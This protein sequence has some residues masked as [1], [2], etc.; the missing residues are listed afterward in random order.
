MQSPVK[1]D[2]RPPLPL[3]PLTVL[4]PLVVTVGIS[5][6]VLPTPDLRASRPIYLL[7]PV[8][9]SPELPLYPLF[10][11]F[12]LL[13]YP[14]GHLPSSLALLFFSLLLSLPLPDM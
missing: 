4:R 9:P 11:S 8:R 7:G 1:E 12:L 10:P 3:E 2:Q 13:L 5:F 6:F 14:K